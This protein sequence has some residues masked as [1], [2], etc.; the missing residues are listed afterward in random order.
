[1]KVKKYKNGGKRKV[2]KG[3]FDIEIDGKTYVVDGKLVEKIRKDGTVKKRKF[4]AKSPV[5]KIKDVTRYKK[6]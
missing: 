2:T 4:K 1:M 6:Q 3:G 5:A